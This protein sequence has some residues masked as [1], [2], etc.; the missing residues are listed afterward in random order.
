MTAIIEDSERPVHQRS[1]IAAYVDR[2]RN[3]WVFNILSMNSVDF[4]QITQ[5]I[6]L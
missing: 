3:L 6:C 2:K 1:L 5:N 4:D